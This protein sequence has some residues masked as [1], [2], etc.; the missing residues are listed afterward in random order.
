M[1]VCFVLIKTCCMWENYFLIETIRTW[2]TFNLQNSGPK[3]LQG[4]N[5]VILIFNIL[6][7][8]TFWMFTY[9]NKTLRVINNNIR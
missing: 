2:S 4:F 5:K 7:I 3:V 1:I 8:E 9:W 6:N